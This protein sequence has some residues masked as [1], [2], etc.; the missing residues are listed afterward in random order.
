MSKYKSSILKLLHQNREQYLSG[1]RIAEQ[2]SIS[3]TA[4]WKT[5]EMLKSQGFQVRSVHNKGYQLT[6]YPDEW[7]QDM[8]Q[9]VTQQSDFFKQRFVYKEVS[10]TQTVAK[11]KM[12]EITEPFIV[13]SE[14]Q[15][16]GRGRFNRQ[17]NSMGEKGL[18]MTLVLS[19]EVPLHKIMTFNLFLSLAIARTIRTVGGVDAKVK[20]PNDIYI[21]DRKCCG[22]L[23]EISGDASAIHHIICGIGINLNH[24]IQDF[25]VELQQKA[26]SIKAATGQSVNR[27][28]FLEKLLSE[29][30][31]AYH[32]FLTEEFSAIK[33]E[34]KYYSNMWDRRLRY[35]EGRNTIE[36][37]A[38]DILDDGRLVVRS[39][40]GVIHQFISADIEI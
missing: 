33:E 29:L 1:Q 18:W 22:F 25:P 9:L 2:L 11:E 36:G 5:I 38:I 15:T 32:Q 8:M 13:I 19:T 14:I 12:L 4:V 26:T 17:W 27:Y 28:V 10:S 7:D 6:G 31:I 21:D 24:E 39:D 37:Q 35:T 23:T 34:Y 40:D 16:K 3:R 30:E 20:W